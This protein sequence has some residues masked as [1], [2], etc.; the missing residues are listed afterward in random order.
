MDVGVALGPTLEK[1]QS[2]NDT[3]L[4]MIASKDLE[5]SKL[6]RRVKDL[7][8]INL[9]LTKQGSRQKG[10]ADPGGKEG[11]PSVV[12]TSTPQSQSKPSKASTLTTSLLNALESTLKSKP[13]P[14]PQA[15]A[16]NSDDYLS[17]SSSNMSL[18]KMTELSSDDEQVRMRRGVVEIRA[19]LLLFPLV[20]SF[21]RSF[22]YLLI[23]ST[24]TPTH[25]LPAPELL[26]KQ[27]A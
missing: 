7:E 1:F 21:A 27:H 18:N 16:Q 23:L 15:A 22:V 26:H 14:P 17:R 2:L 6:N 19:A 11:T 24:P 3:L 9:K 8:Q 5:I 25:L 4:A 20:R 13:Q 10:Q 12:S